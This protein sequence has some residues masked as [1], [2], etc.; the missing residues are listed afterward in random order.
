M[1]AEGFKADFIQRLINGVSAQ[2][3]LLLWWDHDKDR[4]AR[5]L[6]RTAVP[7]AG[8]LWTSNSDAAASDTLVCDPTEFSAHLALKFGSFL[9]PLVNSTS[10]Q[11]Q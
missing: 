3:R 11:T 8:L 6:A 4:L 10:I 2:Q 1:A 9:L 5:I 7:R